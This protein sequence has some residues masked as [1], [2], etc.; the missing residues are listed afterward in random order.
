M[1]FA[2]ATACA[3]VATAMVAVV[4]ENAIVRTSSSLDV[5]GDVKMTAPSLG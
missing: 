3:G 1:M 4:E 5:L 2:A